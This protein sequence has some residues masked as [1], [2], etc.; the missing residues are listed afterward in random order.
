MNTMK[1]LAAALN[2]FVLGVGHLGKD[3]ERGTR[4]AG[5]KEDSGDLVLYCLGDKEI[6]GAVT[7]TRLAVR[8]NRG[9]KQGQVYPFA[10]RQVAAPEP[11]EDGEPI[12]TMV[13]D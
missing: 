2:C 9:G 5:S 4:G 6:S 11:D 8:K 7:N 12:T 3:K 10:L 1:A 13:V